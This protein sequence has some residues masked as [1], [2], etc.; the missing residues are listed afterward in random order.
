MLVSSSHANQ[1]P[2][3][4]VGIGLDVGQA[5][6]HKPNQDSVG[7]YAD[8]C[9]DPKWLAAKG[10]LFVV[11]DGM[12]GAFGGK[13]ASEMAV[14]VVI[15]SYYEDSDVELVACLERAIQEANRQIKE[16]GEADSSVRGLGTTLVSAVIRGRDLVVANA[17]D[18]RA[19]LL[20]QG[21]LQQLSLDHTLVQDQVRAGLLTPEQA[22]THPQRH[23]LSRNLGSRPRAQPDFATETL[24]DGDTILLC[25]DGLWG[26]VGDDEITALL[27][28]LRGKAAADALV[29]LANRYGGPDNISAL[30][31]HIDGAGPTTT[32]QTEQLPTSLSP[33]TE[34]FEPPLP[35]AATITG[36]KAHEQPP[37]WGR[38]WLVVSAGVG[39]LLLVALALYNAFFSPSVQVAAGIASPTVLTAAPAPQEIEPA[40]E[41]TAGLQPTALP[42]D[43]ELA[44]E[45]TPVRPTAPPTRVATTMPTSTLVGVSAWLQRLEHQ[46]NIRGVAFTSDG[47]TLASVSLDTS[48][49]LWQVRDGKLLLSV[50]VGDDTPVTSI[51]IAP[52]GRTVA[53]GSA[54]GKIKLWRVGAGPNSATPE[55]APAGQAVPDAAAKPR[56]SG[57]GQTPTAQTPGPAVTST[58]IHTLIGHDNAVTSLAFRADGQMMASV[59]DDGIVIVWDT[60]TGQFVTQLPAAVEVVTSLAFAPDGQT[61]AMGLGNGDVKLWQ[62]D[63]VPVSKFALT[64]HGKPVTSVAFSPNGQTVAVGSQD[65]TIELWQI[66][67]GTPVY[68]F[69]QPDGV[70]SVAFAPDGRMLAT[71]SEHG[72]VFLWQIPAPS[73]NNAN[74]REYEAMYSRI[75][76]QFAA[77]LPVF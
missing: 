39:L 59:A 48:M 33:Q 6:Q 72:T 10:R 27:L 17:G 41:P 9:E 38:W 45:P 31:V 34:E 71:G 29:D 11:A 14:Q 25:S 57:F 40:V 21:T 8:Y 36:S 73:A 22:D 56:S 64:G 54:N 70:T 43:V 65:D 23:V 12:G 69:T 62:L 75:F 18:S 52:D 2:Q 51:G 13:E 15:D 58:L 76:A 50:R 42:Q 32:Q 35:G 7:T 53:A 74:R 49:K 16:R 26:P 61:L 46:G 44:V 30:V 3:L 60:R 37:R 55:T 1:E 63:D 28:R 19:Y 77:S 47:Q 68:T 20:R 4:T 24:A 67:T 5:R 66:S